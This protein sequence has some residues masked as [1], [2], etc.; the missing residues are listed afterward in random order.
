MKKLLVKDLLGKSIK[1]LVSLR[2]KSRQSLYDMKLKN[3]LRALNQTHLIK[4][5]R[6]NIARINTAISLKGNAAK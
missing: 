1:E 6:R 2:N 4:V 3:T 5:A